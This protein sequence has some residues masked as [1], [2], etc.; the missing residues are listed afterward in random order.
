MSSLELFLLGPPYIKRDGRAIKV[1][2]HKAIALLAYLAVTHQ[3]HTRDT[4]A[5][6]FWPESSQASARTALRNTFPKLKKA[7]GPGWLEIERESLALNLNSGF[8][9]DVDRFG[10]LLLECQAHGHSTDAVCPACLDSLAEAMTLYRDDFMAGFTLRD[11]PGFDEWQ[12]LQ[13]EHWRRQAGSALERLARGY[14]DRKELGLA[15]A[16]ARRWLAVDPLN[17]SAHRH[18]MLLYTQAG[19]RADALQQYEICVQALQHELN[20]L[21]QEETHQLYQDIKK[22]RPLRM[23]GSILASPSACPH[24]LP[25]HP[26]PFLGRENELARL[27]Q[28]LDDASRRLLTVTGV[29][30]VGKTRLALQA[31]LQAVRE[32]SQSFPHGVYLVSLA[33]LDSADYI[34]PAIANALQFSFYPGADP[35]SQLF[36]YL[37]EKELLLVLDN[38]EHLLEGTELLVEMLSHIPGVRFL[39]TSRERLSL[40]WESPIEIRGLA[41][42]QDGEIDA[43][44]ACA[45]V[46]LFLHSVRRVNPEFTL[47]EATRTDVART[48]RYLEGIPLAIELAAAWVETLSCQEIAQGIERDLNLLTASLRD[49]PERHQSLRAAFDHSWR[50]IS[51]EERDVLAKLSVFRGSFGQEAAES[52]AGAS[53]LYLSALTHKSLLQRDSEGKYAMLQVVRQYAEE[54][55]QDTPEWAGAHDRHCEYYANFLHRR[56]QDLKGKKQQEALKEITREIENVRAGWQW[57]VAHCKRDAIVCAMESFFLHCKM[58]S[59]IEEGERA[60]GQ[61]VDEMRK[62]ADE[63]D[64]DESRKENAEL[65]FRVILGN[66]LARQGWFDLQLSR[67]EKAHEILQESLSILRLLGV[68]RD[69]AFALSALSATT[70]CKG[71]HSTAKQLGRESLAIFEKIGD[72]WSMAICLNNLSGIA[73][74]EGDPAQARKYCQKALAIETDLGDQRRRAIAL[75]NLGLI[76]LQ[77]GEYAEAEQLCQQSLA[78]RQEI[79]DR[80]GMAYCY[81]N[82]G[83]AAEAMGEHDKAERYTQ[84]GLALSQKVGNRSMEASCL[85]NLGFV[86]CAM[87]DYEAANVR[88]CTAIEI[89][90]DT[91]FLPVALEAL[92]GIGAVLTQKGERR[93]YAVELAAHALH[94]ALTSSDVKK[95]AMRLLSEL[96]SQLPAQVFAAAQERGK[97][98]ELEHYMGIYGATAERVGCA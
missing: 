67:F 46:Q 72:R 53:L 9:L 85:N 47:S 93:E 68:H 45:G 40:Q 16:Y 69:V 61:A 29:G 3:A 70:V 71:D 60:F 26:T 27:N 75:S 86:L 6:L 28:L 11:S 76:A 77:L 37:R 91:H 64:G 78:I 63:G 58:Q 51:A 92:V 18:L 88:F 73:S 44:E 94:H 62:A 2:L 10:G 49:V 84:Q 97:A 14:S 31:A 7:L 33:P 36:D 5:T 43:L 95:R 54:K 59:W 98:G 96:E 66:L 39:V 4:L 1:G 35:Q 74:L 38:F 48:C 25:L 83:I 87:K 12:S 57:A 15:T 50:L 30:G 20:V 21:P 41:V 42:P 80:L 34:V 19:R 82:L 52:V 17:E 81:S 65:E 8:W 56:E 55:L 24:N 23:P 90:A 89:A 13:A 32:R 22:N 79:G